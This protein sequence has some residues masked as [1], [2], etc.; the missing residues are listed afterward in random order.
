MLIK[1]FIKFNSKDCNEYKFNWYPKIVLKMISLFFLTPLNTKHI[2]QLVFG[3]ITLVIMVLKCLVSQFING[4]QEIIRDGYCE[5]ND[6][7]K[8]IWMSLKRHLSIKQA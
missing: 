7:K 6:H 2:I 3:K 8:K 4:N 5:A 1:Y